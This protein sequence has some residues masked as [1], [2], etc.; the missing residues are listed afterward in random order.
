MTKIQALKESL[1]VALMVTFCAAIIS[2]AREIVDFMQTV[3]G[4]T[5]PANVIGATICLQIVAGFT[6]VF[7]IFSV[8]NKI[9]KQHNAEKIKGDGI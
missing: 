6:A 1:T 8:G 9:R 5:D 4:K 2:R 7:F 3:F